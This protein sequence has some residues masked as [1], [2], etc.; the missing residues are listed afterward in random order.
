MPNLWKNDGTKTKDQNEIINETKTFY[1]NLYKEKPVKPIDLDTVLP[2]EDIP[3]LS[4]NQ[5]QELE[6]Q[7][8]IEEALNSLKNMKNDKSPGSDGFTTEF[9]KFFWKDIGFFIVSSVNFGF[10]KGELSVTQ[11]EGIITCI[12]KGNKD[13]QYLKNWRPISLLNVTYK[14]VSSCIANRIKKN[15]YLS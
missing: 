5:K 10:E 7:I 15:I 1:E 2:F 9:F 12:P 3:K 8:T 4:E 13:K 6:G 11:K 14:I